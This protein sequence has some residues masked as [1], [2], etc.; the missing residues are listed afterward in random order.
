MR[1]IHTGQHQ[2]LFEFLARLSAHVAS[3]L[4]VCP[5]YPGVPLASENPDWTAANTERMK[6]RVPTLYTFIHIC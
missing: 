2:P 6:I 5:V 3:R 4:P 1:F